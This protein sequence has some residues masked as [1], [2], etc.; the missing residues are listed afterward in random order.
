MGCAII[1]VAVVILLAVYFF[2]VPAGILIHDLRDPGLGNGEIPRFTYRWHQILSQ[3]YE[4]WARGRVASGKAEKLDFLDISGTEWPVFGS[5]FYLWA[6]ESL[7]EAWTKDHTL[8]DRKP[9]EYARGAIEAAAALIS[10]PNHASWVKKHWGE[11]YL[12]RENLFY[13]MLLISGLT[14]YEKLLGDK[15]Y[16][17]LL[18]DQ[19]ETLSRE[20]DQSP[21]GLLDDYPEESYPID[22]LPAIAAIRRAD[23]VLGTDHSAF[24]AR[25]VRGFEGKCLDKATGLPAYVTDSKTGQGSGPARGIGISYMLIWSPELW[26]ETTRK[27]YKKFDK[28]FWQEGRLLA[29][30]R[31]FSKESAAENWQF[32]DVDA[33]PV[34]A[35]YGTAACAF[36]IGAAR[37]NGRFDQAYPLSAAAIVAAWPL[38]DGTLLG[39]RILSN[40][41]DAPYVGESAM[42][43]SLTRRPVMAGTVVKKGDTPLV[44]FLGIFFYAGIGGLFI[45]ST[46]VSIRR[47]FKRLPSV[48]YPLPHLQIFLWSILFISGVVIVLFFNLPVGFFPV[49][50]AQ[51]LPRD[52]T[53]N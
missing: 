34:L 12:K 19:V 18:S 35:G 11:D 7:Q 31:E 28:Y 37:A 2:I 50:I 45:L 24:A 13:R 38:P 49:L 9:T 27:W 52:K 47:R 30:F 36:G 40:L 41:S 16:H 6:T 48:Y 32:S 42:L 25:A 51:L 43:F 39:P 33:G 14:S 10:D 8:S 17:R 44:V 23:A 4:P 21:Y 3:K 22:I 29:G 26:P 15:R 53:R 46:V 1:N 20:I 5:V